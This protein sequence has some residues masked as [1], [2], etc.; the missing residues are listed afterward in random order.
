M[1]KSKWP[2]T[3]AKVA[4]L[5]EYRGKDYDVSKIT[6]MMR[7]EFGLPPITEDA[8]FLKIQQLY[9][10]EEFGWFLNGEELSSDLNVVLTTPE[11]DI[12]RILLTLS[13]AEIIDE[14]KKSSNDGA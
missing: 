4:R 5:K 8:V 14:G 7:D 1:G 2:W 3:A 9:T 11:E 12:A 13:I 6:N 10:V